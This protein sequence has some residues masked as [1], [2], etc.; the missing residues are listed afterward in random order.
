MELTQ[1]LLA[2]GVDNLIFHALMILTL[3]IS[4]LVIWIMLKWSKANQAPRKKCIY[5]M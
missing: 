1:V 5:R 2:F 4:A 3:F